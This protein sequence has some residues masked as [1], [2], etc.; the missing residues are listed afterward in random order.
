MDGTSEEGYGMPIGPHCDMRAP[1]EVSRGS[2]ALSL[3]PFTRPPLYRR[4]PPAYACGALRLVTRLHA[5]LALAEDR[6]VQ[7]GAAMWGLGEHTVRD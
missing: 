7:E 1:Q 2:F 4:L 6:S 3:R 5:R